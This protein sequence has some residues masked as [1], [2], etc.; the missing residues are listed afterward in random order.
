MNH[1]SNLENKLCCSYLKN[2]GPFRSCANVLHDWILIIIITHREHEIS[3]RSSYILCEMVPLYW[4]LIR[5][6]CNFGYP[7]E[8][9]H[10]PKWCEISLD[11]DL[12]IS[13]SIVLKIWTE[14]G[15][16]D[17]T[18][19]KFHKCGLPW[20]PVANKRGSRTGRHVCYIFLN[21]KR[22]IF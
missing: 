6:L 20:R 11:H 15:Q 10:K 22:N 8:T 5:S 17:R 3:V 18:I 1:N 7:S 2:N 12:F 16:N 13:Y 9:H 19:S 14:Q 21:I 4:A